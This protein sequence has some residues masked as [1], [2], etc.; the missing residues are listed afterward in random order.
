M[1][2]PGTCYPPESRFCCRGYLFYRAIFPWQA[3]EQIAGIA[4]REL[5]GLVDKSLVRRIPL[6]RFELHDLLRQYCAEKLSQLPV[7]KQET[8]RR[9]CAYYKARLVAW[10]EQLNTPQQGQALCE[11]ETDLT[12]IQAAW[13]WAVQ[14]NY[15]DDFEQTVDGLCMFYLRRARFKEGRD[16]CQAAFDTIQEI[17]ALPELPTHGAALCTFARMAQRHGPEHGKT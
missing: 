1:T 8:K 13:D 15:F 17:T 5:S 3:A 14:H 6:G 9:H 7:D 16:A 11:I 2:I 10:N 4:L 12:N